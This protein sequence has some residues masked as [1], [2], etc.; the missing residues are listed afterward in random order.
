MVVARFT[1]WLSVADVLPPNALSPLYATVRLCAHCPGSGGE[2]GAAADRAL[3]PSGRVASPS[4]QRAGRAIQQQP[5]VAALGAAD[6]GGC[7]LLLD[8]GELLRES[9]HL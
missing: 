1:V 9:L 7:G 3:S 8:D 2:G 5:H 4:F 6:G